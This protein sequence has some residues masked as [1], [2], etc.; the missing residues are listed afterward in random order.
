MLSKEQRLEITTDVIKACRDCDLNLITGE[1]IGIAIEELE[2]VVIL[3]KG[4][5]PE[6]TLAARPLSDVLDELKGAKWYIDHE[7]AK[8]N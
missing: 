2:P 7:Q 5:C 8:K 6:F 1:E 4:L 3:L